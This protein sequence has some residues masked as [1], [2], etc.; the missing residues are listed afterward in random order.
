MAATMVK[1]VAGDL[2]AEVRS[3]A[4]NLRTRA[5]SVV[6]NSPYITACAATVTGI[7]AGVMIGN[8]RR[9]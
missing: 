1:L 4:A 3:D 9:A 7:I 5:G 8:R 2:T 6:K